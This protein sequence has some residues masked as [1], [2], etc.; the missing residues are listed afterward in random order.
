M[1]KLKFYRQGDV[2]LFPLKQNGLD[3]KILK[4]I[5]SKPKTEHGTLTVALGETSGHSHVVEPSGIAGDV[6]ILSYELDRD[7]HRRICKSLELKFDDILAE[8]KSLIGEA[9]QDKPYVVDL[10]GGGQIAHRDADQKL[11]TDHHVIP[12]PI[13]V[14]YVVHQF[15]YSQKGKVKVWD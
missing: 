3:D 11:T 8:A 2:W 13:D 1:K 14:Y 7:D 9:P 4:Q 6:S 12:L 10:R 5:Q 15:Q